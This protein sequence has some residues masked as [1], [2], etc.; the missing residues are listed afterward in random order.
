MPKEVERPR[1]V[2]HA[3]ILHSSTLR[4]VSIGGNGERMVSNDDTEVQADVE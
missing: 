1:T 2:S 4:T 3:D